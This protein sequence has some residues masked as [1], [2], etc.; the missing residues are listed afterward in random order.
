VALDKIRFDI[1]DFSGGLNE[2]D[3]DSKKL[4]SECVYPTENITLSRRGAI[5]KRPGTVKH[6]PDPVDGDNPITGMY[7]GYL[8]KQVFWSIWGKDRYQTASQVARVI[9]SQCDDVILARA[10]P[11]GDYADAAAANLLA[12]AL[13]CPILLV[14]PDSF[15]STT[16]QTIYE[17]GAS[18]IYIMGREEAISDEMKEELEDDPEEF[19]VQR[20]GGE[21]RIETA[22]LIAEEVNQRASTS[23]VCYIV[24]FEAKAD[25]IIAGPAVA[26]GC[27]GYRPIF[28][29][30]DELGSG[31][32][33]T[34]SSLGITEAVIIGGEVRVPASIE[35]ELNSFLGSEN[36]RRIAGDTR[37]HTALEF[38]DYLVNDYGFENLVVVNGDDD[39]CIDGGI[40]GVLAARTKSVIIYVGK[41]HIYSYVD[42]WMDDYIEEGTKVFVI[43]GPV[44]TNADV[45]GQIEEKT[46]APLPEQYFL[47]VAGD[48][49]RRWHEGQ[50]HT[51]KSG[52]TPGAD[53]EFVPHRYV[54]Y[55]VNGV[56]GYMKLG[57]DLLEN[58]FQV[59]DVKPYFP[60]DEEL[61]SLGSNVIPENPKFL[62]LHYDR[63]W[64]AQA[65]R[66]RLR[67]Y[68]SD[69][70]SAGD[71]RETPFKMFRPD[72]FP[73]NNYFDVPC[74]MG[75][76]VTGMVIYQD[77]PH[78]FTRHNVWTVYGTTPPEYQLVLVRGASGAIS[79]RSIREA[80]GMLLY[81]SLDGPMAFD[82][83][84]VY[85]LYEKIPDTLNRIDRSTQ[86]RAAGV[87]HNNRY[88]LALP[89][90]K[91]ND[92]VLEFDLYTDL[93]NP[94]AQKSWVPHKGFVPMCWLVDDDNNALFGGDDSYVYRYGEGWTDDGE[95]YRSIYTTKSIAG[96]NSLRFRRFRV[97]IESVDS[98]ISF[99][100]RIDYG[101]W[102]SK[103]LD[104]RKDPFGTSAIVARSI[105][106]NI[107]GDSVQMQVDHK[108]DKPF[109]IQAI[110]LEAY[111][112]R[113]R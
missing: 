107:I 110:H 45:W 112:K 32:M 1:D 105:G 97:R 59:K 58:A 22:Q 88:Y 42:E 75:D 50:W 96:E 31:N 72:Y 35:S 108:D 99:R 80:K 70:G 89:E 83:T 34:M 65:E 102:F 36:V 57:E 111:V 15:P 47:A 76:K 82:G 55:M 74:Q 5:S 62:A 98:N 49:L 41:D 38:A 78:I 79:H 77:R 18:N 69:I 67:V 100:Y 7:L 25:A 16:M 30:R 56:D 86:E 4:L 63:V 84:N 14:R 93:F 87:V 85:E 3:A 21:T 51:L 52:L 106:A 94:E 28:Y 101:R 104:M 9:F 17:L 43:G 66:D 40:S 48:K 6:I 44:A 109:Y 27:N 61:E 37:Y 54:L 46:I 13:N 95:E 8:Q 11:G 73:A 53:M 12:G 19:T 113:L 60:T 20:I 10:D 29:V 81:H 68:M 90:D 92:M 71:A 23:N 103:F 33:D 24:G 91:Q 64:M 26:G 39:H 2:R